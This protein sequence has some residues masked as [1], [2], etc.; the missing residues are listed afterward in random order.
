MTKKITKIFQNWVEY[1]LGWVW[2][3]TSVNWNT[4]DVTVNEVP[5]WWTDWQV[6][7][8]VS[9]SVAWANPSWGWWIQNDTTWTTTTINK[10]RAWTEAEFSSLSNKCNSTIYFVF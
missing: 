3:V 2:W 9:W 10:E 1:E 5:S 7:S 8:K 4:W 6:L